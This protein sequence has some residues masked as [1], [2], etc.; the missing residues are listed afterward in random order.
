MSA[1]LE[2]ITHF[3]PKSINAHGACSLEEPQPKFLPVNNIFDS[4]YG[5]LFKTKSF[6]ISHFHHIIS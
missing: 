2:L 5:F 6:I 1:K 4:S 3:I